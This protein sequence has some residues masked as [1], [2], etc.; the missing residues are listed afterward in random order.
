VK[1]P[2]FHAT[3]YRFN[4][5]ITQ[6]L[7][8]SLERL[9]QGALSLSKPSTAG[10]L[11]KA[12]ATDTLLVAYRRRFLQTALPPNMG[13][14]RKR[15]LG[16]LPGMV[17]M[18]RENLQRGDPRMSGGI[19]NR[20]L[21]AAQRVDSARARGDAKMLATAKVSMQSARERLRVALKPPRP[22][23]RPLPNG[24]FRRLAL[25]VL[26]LIADI[27]QAQTFAHSTGVVLGIGDVD[28]LD[29]I[30][31]PSAT[32]AL[33]GKATKSSRNIL[34]RHLEFGTGAF[35]TDPSSQAARHR[36]PGGG[37]WYGRSKSRSL[38]LRGSRAGHFMGDPARNLRH[39]PESIRFF[40]SVHELMTKALF[41]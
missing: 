29:R 10:L 19:V 40:S 2:A 37:W 28:L 21:R 5:K 30:R 12:A 15:F 33:T 25:R 14:L 27:S 32:Q 16:A 38:H 11:L 31:T 24:Q 3:H 17:N 23:K 9:R 22:S 7:P 26:E 36:L 39:Q 18:R 35:S 8:E 6:Q 41:G 34:W 20:Y 4:F 1:S 13:V